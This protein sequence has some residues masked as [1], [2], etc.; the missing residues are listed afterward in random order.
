MSREMHVC[1]S[2]GIEG[3]AVAVQKHIEDKH[4]RGYSP[5]GAPHVDVK[6]EK[7]A[8]T[9]QPGARV[10][11]EHRGE[12]HSGT[13]WSEAPSMPSNGRNTPHR[14]VIP[15]GWRDTIPLP[16]KA[17]TETSK[18][19]AASRNGEFHTAHPAMPGQMEF[20]EIANRRAAMA[21]G[22]YPKLAI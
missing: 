4:A 5:Y 3:T 13:V 20:G 6:S 8:R 12:T 19:L 14:H 22:T 21:A 15:D 1:K 2:C 9:H 17:L 7:P 16:V 10:T 18:P 11:W